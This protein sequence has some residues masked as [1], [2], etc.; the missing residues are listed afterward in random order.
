MPAN[1][2]VRI[3]VIYMPPIDALPG[4]RGTDG[5]AARLARSLEHAATSAS[6]RFVV[7]SRTERD[8]RSKANRVVR[9]ISRHNGQV[10]E[11]SIDVWTVD[12]HDLVVGR[13]E[14]RSLPRKIWQALSAM[15]PG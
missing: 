11:R 13:L 8:P 14:H 6:S 5:L 3:A 4:D 7:E 1:P 15:I 10:I 2:T 9:R 12:Y